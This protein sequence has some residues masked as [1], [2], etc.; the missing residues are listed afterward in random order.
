M[1]AVIRAD[2]SATIGHGH[3][4]R[5]LALA[6][7]LRERG[8]A[9]IHFLLRRQP[10]D[11]VAAIEQAGCDWHALPDDAADA[12]RDA[13]ASAALLRTLG[14]TDL[15]VLDHYQ[16]GAD[17]V[18]TVRP[19]ARCVLVIDDLADRPLAGDLLLDQNWHDDAFARYR[20]VWPAG[21]KTLFGPAY[22]LLRPEFAAARA[23]RGPRDGPLKRVV[24]AFGGS[25]P[26][27]ATE[28][29]LATLHGAHPA[30]HYDVIIGSGAPQGPAVRERWAKM[31]Q[32]E[33]TI[34]AHD[35][36]RRFAL[37]DLF[38]GAGG[39]MTWERASLGL[40]GIT[41]PIAANQQPLCAKLAAAGEG[42]D[43]GAFDASKM[44]PLCAALSVLAA[45]PEA[46]RDMATKIARRCD[47]AG[48]SRVAAAVHARLDAV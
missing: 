16:R 39:S 19:Q 44:P 33:V 48:A 35:I 37:A 40:P 12:Q 30:L 15:L 14:G 10:G 36:A 22:A 26:D 24:I 34:G 11:A 6:G 7:A 21:G 1:R 13:E 25:D 41:L 38:V 28:A 45:R 3:V 8:F 18:T 23:A 47:G 42:I 43:L 9:S 32:V 2:A 31:P 29:C 17:W 27:N 5:C 4:M 46:V 20:P